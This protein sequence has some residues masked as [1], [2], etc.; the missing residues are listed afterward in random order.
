MP[1]NKQTDAVDKTER[2]SRDWCAELDLAFAKTATRTVLARCRHQGPLMVQRPFYPEGDLCHVYI[3]HPPGGVVAGDQLAI[4]I[5]VE[6]HAQALLT[7]PA[8][9]KF[10]KSNG[11]AAKQVLTISVAALA[12]LEWLPQETI[13]FQ[14]AQVKTDIDIH[15]VEASRFIA[16]EIM[17]LGR[18]AAGEGFA[19]G[20][21]IVNWRLY[22]ASSLIF[23]ERQ[24]L[25]AQALAAVWGFNN[26]PVSGSLFAYPATAVHLQRIQALIGEHQ[27]HGVT[28]IDGLLICRGLDQRADRLRDFFA[29][30][31]CVLRPEVIGQAPCSPRIWAT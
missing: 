20:E 2:D 7:T 5:N 11:K 21:I 31:W 30:V 6:K 24:I 12:S 22:L 18:P 13:F 9:G 29:Q 15:I 23:F 27:Y 26:F 28:L 8:A 4:N 19:E 17:V 14:G 10:Y 3:L 16:W 25:N 1:E